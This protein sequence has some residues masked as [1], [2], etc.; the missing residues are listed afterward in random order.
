MLA[1]PMSACADSGPPK[2]A[3]VPTTL[4]AAPATPTGGAP[5]LQLVLHTYGGMP[6]AAD[7]PDVAI[8]ANGKVVAT[9]WSYDPAPATPTLLRGEISAGQLAAV[10]ALARAAQ[11][12]R[13]ESTFIKSGRQVIDGGGS[14]FVS[15]LDGHVSSVW[16]DQLDVIAVHRL[17]PA[18]WAALQALEKS[19]TQLAAGASALVVGDWTIRIRPMPPEFA[20]GRSP[21]VGPPFASISERWGPNATRCAVLS[22]PIGRSALKPLGRDTAFVDDGEPADVWVR[23]LLPHERTCA[24]TALANAELLTPQWPATA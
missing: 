12:D 2:R 21:W 17:E 10:V 7:L 9:K 19:M 18:R 1:W 11:L 6:R 16:A 4:P 14:Q 24:D 20:N 5:I 22:E 3:E 13:D 8:Y 15:L 23:P